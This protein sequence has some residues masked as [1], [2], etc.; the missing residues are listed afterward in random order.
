MPKKTRYIEIGLRAAITL[1][2]PAYVLGD[3][4]FA[5][6]GSYAIYLSDPKT[7]TKIPL[8]WGKSDEDKLKLPEDL[9]E[10]IRCLAENAVNSLSDLIEY[11]ET[12][13]LKP[14]DY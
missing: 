10:F 7:D 14:L 12:G 9:Y 3:L 1:L 5:N 13:E 11:N 4:F 6:E 2:N 8:V